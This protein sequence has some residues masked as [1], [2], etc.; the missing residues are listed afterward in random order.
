M[1]VEYV[2]ART[3]ERTVI[4]SPTTA[5]SGAP[6]G[7]EPGW[8]LVIEPKSR[9]FDL[10]L[11]ELWHYRDLVYLFVWRD[12]VARYKQT[13]LGPAWH[14]IQ[15]LVTTA[16][17]TAVF[18]SIAAI[19]TDNAP[20]FLFYMV[21]TMLWG[22]FSDVFGSTSTTFSANA[23]LFGKVYFPRLAVPIATLFSRLIGL[24]IQ[25]A[26]LAL[27]LGW[28]IYRGA[29][30]QPNLWLLATPLLLLMTA[31]LALGLG[32]IV[33]ALTT[34]DRDLTIVVSFGT[35]LL[36]FATPI[37]YPLSSVPAAY[38]GW[39]ALN[40]LTPIVEVFR[41]AFLGTGVVDLT[42]LAISGASTAVILLAGVLI[43]THVERNFLDTV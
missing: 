9:L 39:M 26:F 43:F 30:V 15:P 2:F 38:R 18:G 21:G 33:S 35:Q 11:G 25:T 23:N 1:S 40:P 5:E 20:P 17:F 29:H 13:I 27:F 8:D 10:K 37:I 34:R 28:F 31:M 41:Y 36:M 16:V 3:R 6:V 42:L 22:Y 4:A 7:G 19:P 12:F 32:V 14:V 24:A